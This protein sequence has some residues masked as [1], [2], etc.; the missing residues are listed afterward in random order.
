[1]KGVVPE[2]VVRGGEGGGEGGL[3]GCQ[4]VARLV[5]GGMGERGGAAY[6]ARA[7]LLTRICL[8]VQ[9]KVRARK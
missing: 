2:R 3:R 8:P 5:R 6:W 1:M 7:A 4:G 9:A